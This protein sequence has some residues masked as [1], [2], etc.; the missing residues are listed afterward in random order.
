MVCEHTRGENRKPTTGIQIRLHPRLYPPIAEMSLSTQGSL[1]WS[2]EFE[3]EEEEEDEL[4]HPR[5]AFEADGL[6]ELVDEMIEFLASW[7]D[8]AVE[9]GDVVGLQQLARTLVDADFARVA[10]RA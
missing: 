7:R 5:Q 9:S 8:C 3:E 6:V 1:I 10:Q 2:Y 4:A